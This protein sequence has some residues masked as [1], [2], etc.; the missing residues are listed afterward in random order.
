VKI[1]QLTSGQL[2][3][4]LVNSGLC[5]TGGPFV[6]RIQTKIA[7][8]AEGL[9]VLY[10]DFPI[11]SRPGFADFHIRFE[12]TR[13]WRRG[14]RPHLSVEVDGDRP[15]NELPIEQSQ[16]VLEGCLN[17]C[18]YTQAHQYLII[19]AAAVERNG[20]AAILPAP[21]G[22]GKS[23][24]C[25][26]LVNRGWR[27]LTDELTLI[28][29]DSRTIIPLARPVSLKNESINVIKDFAPKAVFGPVCPNTIKGTV[30]HMKP[31]PESVARVHEDCSA[32]WL[33]VPSYRF[34]AA[35]SVS[36]ITKGEAFMRVAESAV[37][38]MM[39]GR[40]G[41][42]V[43]SALID[44]MVC[45]RF[46]YSDLNEAVQRFDKLTRS[47]EPNATNIGSSNSE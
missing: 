43:V 16:A 27:L 14:F 6:F 47:D 22:S 24:L 9:R 29:T 31:P 41:F 38:Y 46:E 35:T 8:I 1:S 17:W 33:I 26:A 21:P 20:R 30:A 23:T 19:H 37:N 25:A 3:E 39:L 36:E 10:G 18:I 28:A 11:A 32:A 34:G 15:A 7:Q 45:C 42:E 13:R 4:R 5:L 2:R 40:I 12:E 44:E